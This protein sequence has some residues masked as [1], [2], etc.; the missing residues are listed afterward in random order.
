MK[1]NQNIRNDV[2]AIFSQVVR[3]SRFGCP[4][5]ARVMSSEELRTMYKNN[6]RRIALVS[7]PIWEIHSQ[8]LDN[9]LFLY[10]NL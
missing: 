7:R 3:E 5:I 2:P 6:L 8:D 10:D 4:R 9:V 1:R